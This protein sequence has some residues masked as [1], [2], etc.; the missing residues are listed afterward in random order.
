MATT[1]A[2]RD[3]QSETRL[4]R[5]GIPHVLRWGFLGVLVFMT[6]L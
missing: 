6:G 1:E 2:A 5:L 4:D 3:Q